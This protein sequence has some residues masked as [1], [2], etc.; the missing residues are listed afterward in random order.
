MKNV[1]GFGS[2]VWEGLTLQLCIIVN[3]QLKSFC[4]SFLDEWNLPGKSFS[5]Q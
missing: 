3:P 5:G 2:L 4:H 1:K